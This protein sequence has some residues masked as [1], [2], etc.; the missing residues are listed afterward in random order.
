MTFGLF[1][2]LL[3]ILVGGSVAYLGNQFV[4]RVGR[5]KI[6]FMGLRPRYTSILITILVGMFISFFTV[7]IVAIYSQKAKIALLGV[8]E[9]Q[10]RK[11]KLQHEIEELNKALQK[12]SAL[13]QLNEPVSMGVVR[14]DAGARDKEQQLK[15]ILTMA[16]NEVQKKHEEEAAFL[17]AGLLNKEQMKS[18]VTYDEKEYTRILDD[19]I[20]RRDSFVVLL[21]SKNN[22]Y[23]REPLSLGFSLYPD[24]RLYKKGD[25]LLSTHIRAEGEEDKVFFELLAFLKEME[26]KAEQKGMLRVPRTKSMIDISMAEVTSALQKIKGYKGW[27]EISAYALDDI[28]TPGPLSVKLA[29]NP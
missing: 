16:Q 26:Q 10:V 8:K 4:R 11:K 20:A 13:F 18:L 5:R 27:V 14:G 9:L 6:S 2:I 17:K 7:T 12:S 3:V 22:A 23:F 28:Y 1:I 15:K 19:L 24:V 29:I 21:F 25:T